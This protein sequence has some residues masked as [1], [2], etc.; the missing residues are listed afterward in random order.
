M[1]SSPSPKRRKI[2]LQVIP[3]SSKSP[4]EIWMHSAMEPVYYG[5]D[6]KAVQGATA[7]TSLLEQCRPPLVRLPENSAKYTQ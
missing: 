4:W 3:S 2:F 5:I 1:P 6:I 7:A